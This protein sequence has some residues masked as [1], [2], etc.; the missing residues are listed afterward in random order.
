MSQTNLSVASNMIHWNLNT[1]IRCFKFYEYFI[2][3][4]SP[5]VYYAKCV[6]DIDRVLAFSWIFWLLISSYSCCCGCCCC[7][8][9][10]FNLVTK[11]IC[12]RQRELGLHLTQLT[13][14]TKLD[15][16]WKKTTNFHSKVAQISGI[17][18]DSFKNVSF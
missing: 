3:N 5:S 18:L 12:K 14:V 1:L 15:Y 4:K 11:F 8:S 6:H 10:D 7:C 13:S 17:F 2:K 16:F 9:N